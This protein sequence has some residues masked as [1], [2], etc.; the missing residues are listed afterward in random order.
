MI[1]PTVDSTN[2]ERSSS[3]RKSSV[4][5]RPQKDFQKVLGKE[6]DGE[7]EFSED[8]G[9]IKEGKGTKDKSTFDA[10]AAKIDEKNPQQTGAVS[11]FA[12]ATQQES[13]TIDPEEA[14]VEDEFSTIGM[15]E[16]MKDESLS[17]LFK[18]YGTKEK[19]MALMQTIKPNA[20]VFDP[21]GKVI[22]MPKIAGEMEE[23]DRPQNLLFNKDKGSERIQ[24]TSR[25]QPDLSSINPLAPQPTFNLAATGRVETSQTPKTNTA[26]IQEIVDQIIANLY[27]LE[28]GGRTDTV[29]TL[30]YP[31]ILEGAN[32]VITSFSTAKGEFNVAF[33]NLTQAA[34]QLLDA[35]ENQISLRSALEE[36]GYTVHI[37][38]T[39]T[40]TETINV[41][42][43]DQSQR[44]DKEGRGGEDRGQRQQREQEEKEEA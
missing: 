14:A 31:P 15:S 18:G 3:Y 13:L 19:L 24:F 27:T 1:D 20:A 42:Q 40:L 9:K 33:E 11:L 28:V 22:P 35:K 8:Q 29:V 25:E 23:T 6:R 26:N 10:A 12:L 39:T 21:E 5:G 2:T 38:T 37:V 17:A 32:L 36:K 7:R 34:K 41:S 4:S 30:K 44:G 16:E 43:S